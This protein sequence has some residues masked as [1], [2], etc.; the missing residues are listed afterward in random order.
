MSPA[1][2]FPESPYASLVSSAII[3][4]KGTRLSAVF[5]LVSTNFKYHLGSPRACLAKSLK[6]IVSEVSRQLEEKC[7]GAYVLN[8]ELPLPKKLEAVEQMA[9]GF[10]G[11]PVL[12]AIK[13]FRAIARLAGGIEGT[14][15]IVREDDNE[16]VGKVKLA[17]KGVL[18]VVK[19]GLRDMVDPALKTASSAAAA[20]IH[21][22]LSLATPALACAPRWHKSTGTQQ[23]N[24]HAPRF[25]RAPGRSRR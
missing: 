12:E 18:K 1:A 3:E 9:E 24:R 25:R 17:N 6:N 16:L 20:I 10:T 14:A 22:D 15:A 2:L 5:R 21:T 8:S 13:G 7:F 19:E 23:R 4:F 11:E